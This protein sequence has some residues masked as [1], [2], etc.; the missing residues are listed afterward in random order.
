ME[1]EMSTAS[2]VRNQRVWITL[3]AI[4]VFASSHGYGQ[5]P[6]GKIGFW[7]LKAGIGLLPED[8]DRQAQIR[9][10][11]NVHGVPGMFSY[12][13]A[14]GYEFVSPFRLAIVGDF[15][16][17]GRLLLSQDMNKVLFEDVY[18]L[19]PTAGVVFRLDND[20]SLPI[21][22]GAGYY[23]GTIIDN[24]MASALGEYVEGLS[25]VGEIG[26]R[27]FPVG[28]PWLGL[29]LSG[30]FSWYDVNSDDFKITD[31]G[32]LNIGDFIGTFRFNFSL[33]VPLSTTRATGGKGRPDD[34]GTIEF[35]PPD[36]HVDTGTNGKK[37]TAPRKDCD[38]DLL[39]GQIVETHKAYIYAEK[40]PPPDGS[41]GTLLSIATGTLTLPWNSTRIRVERNKENGFCDIF[42]NNEY[43]IWADIYCPPTIDSPIVPIISYDGPIFGLG[44]CGLIL[45]RNG[46]N[47]LLERAVG[48]IN[49]LKQKYGDNINIHVIGH[50]D[51]V[52]VTDKSF[53]NQVPEDFMYSAAQGYEKNRDWF[54]NLWLGKCRA[55]AV[56]DYLIQRLRLSED[57]ITAS[58]SGVDYNVE[59]SYESIRNRR[60]EILIIPGNKPLRYYSEK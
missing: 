51:S 35:L 38:C 20:W 8:G 7:W 4:L 44:Q 58:S 56:R 43:N 42:I 30:K 22:I 34:T 36:E 40:Q 60:V 6:S 41:N 3:F 27:Y 1:Q 5:S 53:T 16:R 57:R 49:T 18:S 54:Y 12:N 31:E 39:L 48:R 24:P 47:E 33:T 21:D 19:H 2:Y 32:G 28:K 25:L 52:R 17:V 46:K 14:L 10:E 50:T 26:I 15:G 11:F 13:Y 59:K 37:H 29:G 55:E 9:N 23:H 45:D